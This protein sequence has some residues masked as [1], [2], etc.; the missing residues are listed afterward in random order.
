[1]MAVAVIG[2]VL[3]MMLTGVMVLARVMMFGAMVLA[4][5]VGAVVFAAMM[6]AGVPPA[7][8]APMSA[9]GMHRDSRDRGAHERR[10]QRVPWNSFQHESPPASTKRRPQERNSEKPL[11]R[12][13]PTNESGEKQC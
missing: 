4:A 10:R 8:A 12:S 2:M 9:A 1:M 6:T 13:G 7:M 3:R 5:F 11:G